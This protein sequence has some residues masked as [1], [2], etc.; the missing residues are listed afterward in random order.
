MNEAPT[1][2]ILSPTTLP[3]N[4]PAGTRIGSITVVDPDT[5]STASCRIIQGSTDYFA[6][7]GLQLVSGTKKVDYESLGSTK[8]LT[9]KLRCADEYG[10]FLDKLFHISITGKILGLK[11]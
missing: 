4:S 11:L 3:E 10:L 7:S 1:D 8:M 2:L 5:N 6:V 9:V